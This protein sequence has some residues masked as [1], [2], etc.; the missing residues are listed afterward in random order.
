[1]AGINFVLAQIQ[2]IHRY[3]RG[4]DKP[5][6]LEL[7]QSVTILVDINNQLD[8]GKLASFPLRMGECSFYA[9][10]QRLRI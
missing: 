5:T 4:T 8:G 2:L 6:V 9:V 10:Q 7:A 1:V 3:I